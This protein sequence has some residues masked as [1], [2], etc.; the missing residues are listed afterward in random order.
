M[1]ACD[2]LTV[3]VWFEFDLTCWWHK[4]TDGSICSSISE[5]E[6]PNEYFRGEKLVFFLDWISSWRKTREIKTRKRQIQNE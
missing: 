3:L 1:S 6:I 4:E 2:H 5:N